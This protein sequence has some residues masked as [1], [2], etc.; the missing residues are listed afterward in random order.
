M[1]SVLL[2][3]NCGLWIYKHYG[4][5]CNCIWILCAS[6]LVVSVFVICGKVPLQKNS[7]ILPSLYLKDTCMQVQL[8]YLY[9]LQL[10]IIFSK[11]RKKNLHTGFLIR[12]TDSCIGVCVIYIINMLNVH[13][14]VKFKSNLIN[15][16]SCQAKNSNRAVCICT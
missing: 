13:N 3:F 4:V 9:V 6:K 14:F 12:E 16:S 1:F 8:R 2:D 11:K 7:K 15:F 5:I 10:I